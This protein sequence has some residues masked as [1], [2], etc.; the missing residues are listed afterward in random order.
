LKQA[1][2]VIAGG[3][4]NC[5]V[6][7]KL[8]NS[9]REFFKLAKDDVMLKTM[10]SFKQTDSIERRRI[11]V[12]KSEYSSFAFKKLTALQFCVSVGIQ[13]QDEGVMELLF[14]LNDDVS[15]KCY[16]PAL[17]KSED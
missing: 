2:D 1:I 3:K 5:V 13:L 15:I 16:V 6:Y 10:V 8:D 17:V 7:L 11:T 9:N 4:Q 14:M 12:F